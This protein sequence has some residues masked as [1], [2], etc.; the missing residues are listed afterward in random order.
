MPLASPAKGLLIANELRLADGDRKDACTLLGQKSRN[1]AYHAQQAAEKLL[2]A[3]LTSEDT[4]VER[5]DAHQL[6]TLTNRLLADHPLLSQ[7]K[8]LALPKR[9]IARHHRRPAVRRSGIAS[10]HAGPVFTASP[11]ASIERS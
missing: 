8:P 3:L 4:Y 11:A 5:K 9:L 6:D 10:R 7:L 1:A 2:L